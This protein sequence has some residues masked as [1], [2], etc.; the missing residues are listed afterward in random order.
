[1]ENF[2]VIP[3]ILTVCSFNSTFSSGPLT[4]MLTHRHK[5]MWVVCLHAWFRLRSSILKVFFDLCPQAGVNKLRYS[6]SLK[7]CHTSVLGTASCLLDTKE[8]FTAQSCEWRR[9]ERTRSESLFSRFITIF[10]R[11]SL[12]AEVQLH[13]FY[14]VFWAWRIIRS[15]CQSEVTGIFTS[16][17][18]FTPQIAERLKKDFYFDERSKAR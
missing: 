14:L 18:I 2:F 12:R 16:E 13:L 8:C 10:T 5:T 1:M 17:D 11:N 7:I 3:I 9:W 6:I 15:L 4:A